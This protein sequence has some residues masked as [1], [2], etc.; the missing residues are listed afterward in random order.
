MGLRRLG[1]AVAFDVCEVRS[2]SSLVP[3][4]IRAVSH[5]QVHALALAFHCRNQI[6]ASAHARLVHMA[7]RI[8]HEILIQRE[9]P[10]LS[11]NYPQLRVGGLV[12]A[13]EILPQ[14]GH[15]R[16]ESAWM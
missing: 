8:G 10:R 9:F 3:E 16:G 4:M 14:G 2:L 5:E 15:L 12:L 7:L 6:E 11:F 1:R 13:E